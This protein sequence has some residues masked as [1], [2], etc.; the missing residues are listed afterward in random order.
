MKSFYKAEKNISFLDF[1]IGKEE[2]K[3][4]IH[5]IVIPFL[6][7]PINIGISLI[8]IVFAGMIYITKEKNNPSSKIFFNIVLSY[9]IV[10]TSIVLIG[11]FTA[12]FS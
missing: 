3:G 1:S 9:I 10:L 2:I 7:M 4:I 6:L 12:S 8:Y 5:A 11:I